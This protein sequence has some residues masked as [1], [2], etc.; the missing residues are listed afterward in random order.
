MRGLIV[1]GFRQNGHEDT[2]E[3]L[4]SHFEHITIPR[5]N[6]NSP[7]LSRI[8]DQFYDQLGGSYDVSI[9]FSAGSLLALDAANRV[10]PSSLILCSPPPLYGPHAQRYVHHFAP[11][12]IS[13][14][15]LE[16]IAEQEPVLPPNIAAWM[17]YGANEPSAERQS[18]FLNNVFF[19]GNAKLVEIENGKHEING[20]SYQ[21]TLLSLVEQITR[22]KEV[23]YSER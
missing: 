18:K 21:S 4:R 22:S 3:R 10:N 8:R 6:W 16:E 9:G 5:I 20:E 13:P 14:E 15:L 19:N 17:L 11:A 12:G 2:Y 7:S 23:V 1:P